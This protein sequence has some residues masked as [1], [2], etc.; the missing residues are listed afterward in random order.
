MT[1]TTGD[2]AE[3]F[4]GDERPTPPKW[5]TIEEIGSRPEY[6][7]GLQPITTGFLSLDAPLNGGFRP[8]STYVM[9]GRTA[10]GKTTLALNMTRRIALS[11]HPVLLF[12]LEESPTE[13]VWRIHAAASGVPLAVL[14]DGKR[15]ADPQ[16]RVR[17]DDAWDLIRTLVIR[18]SADRKLAAMEEISKAHVESNGGVIIVD[19]LSLIDVPNTQVGFERATI[20]TNTLRLLARDLR[21]PIVIVA[22]VNRNAA[23]GKDELTCND[24]RDSGCIEN[25]ASAV[26]LIDR[27]KEPTGPQYGGPLLRY[28]QIL[29]DKNR[30]G[31]RTDPK[32]PIELAWWPESA[33]VED[34]TEVSLNDST[35][36]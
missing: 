27:I 36:A 3:E 17:L 18:V 28:M 12:K 1:E 11:G 7:E 4:A 23:K 13:A 29:I 30:Y 15:S 35:A 14:L 21:V 34:P 6:D 10:T 32:M 2:V 33:R 22:Q 16:D 25:D 20:I 24:L 19:Q 26:I 8:E 31:P 9:S 5:Q